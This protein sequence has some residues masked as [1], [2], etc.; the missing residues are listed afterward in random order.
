MHRLARSAVLRPRSSPLRSSR[1]VPAR[2]GLRARRAALGG[3]LAAA[4]QLLLAVASPS[5]CA[6]A[7]PE[8]AR[9][10]TLTSVV[11]ARSLAPFLNAAGWTV[12]VTRAIVSLG[13]LYYHSGAPVVARLRPWWIGLGVRIAHA[14]PGHYVQ[15]EVL[16]ESLTERVVDL[17]QGPIVLGA[18]EGVTGTA[19]SA[20]LTFS[21]AP[22]GELARA[23][24]GGVVRI[25]GTAERDGAVLEFGA[26]VSASDLRDS[27][28][29]VGV[30]GCSL[31]DGEIT[32]DGTVTL[33][34]RLEEALDQVDF[35]DLA[36]AGRVDLPPASRAHQALVRGLRKAATYE[37]VF[38]RGRD[39]SPPPEESDP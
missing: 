8:A 16:G 26:T 3:A 17:A 39:V 2:V 18:G 21:E 36:A 14:H 37:F 9:R 7:P 25:E 24:A 13:P 4:L 12:Q 28:G 35:V 32:G 38:T 11:R 20:R 22:S 15:G 23:L 1:L 33:A 30:A 29:T 6:E 19:R 10:V 31:T 5:G 27:T 34:V